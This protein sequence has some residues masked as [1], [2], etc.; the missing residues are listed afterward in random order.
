MNKV[1]G[2]GL[3]RTGT[4][5]LVNMFKILG[6]NTKTHSYQLLLDW[7]NNNMKPLY[8]AVDNHTAL[9]SIPWCLVY[10]EMDKKYPNSKFILTVRNDDERWFNSQLN[11]SLML[12]P[13]KS[14][15][16]DIIRDRI[17]VAKYN[18][19]IF[20]YNYPMDHKQHYLDVYHKHNDDVQKYFKGKNNLLTICFEN[21]D[22]WEEVCEFLDVDVPNVQLPHMNRTDTRIYERL[23]RLWRRNP[24]RFFGFNPDDLEINLSELEEKYT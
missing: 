23:H 18:R 4:T 1:F 8:D 21:G 10:K 24:D 16:N 6:F 9:G 17:R 2:I 7:D 11:M 15:P 12:H 20:K 22:G 19:P 3:T 14:N 5:T 13:D